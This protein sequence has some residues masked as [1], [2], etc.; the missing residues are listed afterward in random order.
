MFN[1]GSACPSG[2]E[3]DS[4]AGNPNH[5]DVCRKTGG[6]GWVCPDGCERPV[7]LKKPWCQMSVGDP[8]T[9]CRYTGI[10]Y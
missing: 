1:S 5:G 6:G 2:Y 9:P 4:K 7:P 10:R 8:F 3:L